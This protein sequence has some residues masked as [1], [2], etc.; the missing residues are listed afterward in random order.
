MTR[1]NDLTK[2]AIADYRIRRSLDGCTVATINRDFGAI[3]SFL[4]WCANDKDLQVSPLVL[5]RQRE[6]AGRERWL[7]QDE[8][9]AV[10][11]ECSDDW[12]PLFACLLYTGM[13][14]GEAQGLRW[15]DVDLQR[16]RISIHD[17]NRRLKTGTSNRDVPIAAQLAPIIA[18]LRAN[19][20]E[21]GRSDL[22]FAGTISDYRSARRAWQRVCLAAGL[23][24][25]GK[26]PKPN[27]RIHDLRHT[28]GVH[29]AIAGV[30]VTSLQR[31]LG[32]ATAIMTLRYMKY[33]GEAAQQAV[34]VQKVMDSMMAGQVIQQHRAELLTGMTA[35]SGAHSAQP[36]KL[37][38]RSAG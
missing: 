19:A 36:L 37:L 6:P 5:K 9:L 15:G 34:D 27:A 16:L 29:A 2:G 25:G 18:G 38:E 1:L 10:L 31:L 13:R 7:K 21:V 14:I 20:G 26:R 22:V 3:A 17:G 8:V 4:T 28:F 12:R 24:D 23:H 32:H 35:H 33:A 30:P 11:A